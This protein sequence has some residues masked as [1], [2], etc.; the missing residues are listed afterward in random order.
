MTFTRTIKL[1]F[2]FSNW[3]NV[4]FE[5][6]FNNF[7]TKFN[8]NATKIEFINI[9]KSQELVLKLNFVK[10]ILFQSNT[11]HTINFFLS[12]IFISIFPNT[13]LYTSVVL[14]SND[15]TF[16]FLILVYF[17]YRRLHMNV[18]FCGAFYYWILVE[19]GAF[20]DSPIVERFVEVVGDVTT[21]ATRDTQWG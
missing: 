8:N 17:N 6:E 13:H 7:S 12:I 5:C 16:N 18:S 21:T 3:T 15:L 14:P 4:N 11:K 19:E 1:Y 2:V 10:Q 9:P 20:G